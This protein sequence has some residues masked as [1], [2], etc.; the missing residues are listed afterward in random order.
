MEGQQHSQDE[1]RLM[2]R[3]SKVDEELT[4]KAQAKGIATE[5]MNKK[6]A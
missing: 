1:T 4:R 5:N 6:E 2:G 3:F